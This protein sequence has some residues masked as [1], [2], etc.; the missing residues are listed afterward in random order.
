M[1]D[2]TQQVETLSGNFA[3]V[4]PGNKLWLKSPTG[5]T[6]YYYDETT[7]FV[8]ANGAG[9]EPASLVTDSVV[10]LQRETYSGS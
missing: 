9:I 6:E 2:P 8:D 7:S 4:A 5:F 10:S 3:M 1:T